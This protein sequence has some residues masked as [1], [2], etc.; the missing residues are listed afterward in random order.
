[1]R[2]PRSV[3]VE[4]TDVVFVVLAVTIFLVVTMEVW[5]PHHQ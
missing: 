2:W 1:M 3:N 5:L 4:W